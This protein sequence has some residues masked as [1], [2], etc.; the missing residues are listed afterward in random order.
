MLTTL[1]KFLLYS[2]LRVLNCYSYIFN[3]IF[4]GSCCIQSQR[5]TISVWWLDVPVFQS[6]I[7]GWRYQNSNFTTKSSFFKYYLKDKF[8]LLY[9]FKDRL[10][11]VRLVLQQS[12]N[13]SVVSIL[14][15]LNSFKT[16]HSV[17]K[18]YQRQD[19]FKFVCMFFL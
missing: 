2:W 6:C 12:A 9:K 13:L 1:W 8:I 18:E 4:P 15:F 3:F 17:S 7:Y 11:I 14:Q 19:I 5:P 16:F 10:K